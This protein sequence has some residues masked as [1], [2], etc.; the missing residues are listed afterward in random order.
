M[1][2]WR[3][4]AALFCLFL[5]IAF[6]VTYWAI[7]KY[8]VIND[9]SAAGD[10][11]SYIKMSRGQYDD[12]QTRYLRRWLVPSMVRSLRPVLKIPHALEKF[13]D[14]EEYKITNLLFGIINIFFLTLTA[15]CFFYFCRYLGFGGWESLTASL[16]FLTS[17]FVITYYTI[18]M[19]DA[20]ASFFVMA[21][22]L[23]ILRGNMFWLSVVFTIG[24]FAK[25]TTFV[26]IGI[27]FLDNWRKAIKFFWVFIPGLITYHC[28]SSIVP[29]NGATFLGNISNTTA[30]IA[31]F[32]SA[33]KAQSAYSMI[34]N[35]QILMFLWF[36]FLY[37][38]I[39]YWKDIP[40]F[41]R[42]QMPLLV[43]IFVT[44]FFV[45][46]GA[47]GRVAFY[48]FPVLIPPVVIVFRGCFAHEK[49]LI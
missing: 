31:S 42:K 43:L 40:L 27:F 45:N 16:L 32:R 19:V 35:F 33:W 28:L 8:N 48:L 11:E 44:P 29:Q 30:L 41:L 3:K 26:L 24:I 20:V 4:D 21:G 13:Y 18:P 22:F 34:E 14:I 37:A 12:I 25:E 38:L 6:N 15:F 49:N 23:A 1:K 17:F 36:L 47:V 39:R 5:S 10:A 7:T 9:L 2:N 46:S